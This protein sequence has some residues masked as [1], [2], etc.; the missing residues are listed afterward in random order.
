MTKECQ[1]RTVRITELAER[2]GTSPRMLRYRE[3]LGLMPRSARSSGRSAAHRR[4]GD[5]ELSAVALALELERRYDVTPAA[6]AFGL[7]VLAEPE[8]AAALREL[9]QRTGRLTP[10][11]ARA[12]DFE[13]ERALRWLGRQR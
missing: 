4:Y 2:V 11:A 3:S 10:P 8:V 13:K 1:N 12:L 9:G 6:L 5:A 7:R